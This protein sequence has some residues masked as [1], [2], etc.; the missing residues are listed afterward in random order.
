MFS[1]VVGK[2]LMIICYYWVPW[3]IDAKHF[4]IIKKYGCIFSLVKCFTN[5]RRCR[6]QFN[7]FKFF[8]FINKD[9][10]DDPKVD[11]ITLFNLMIFIEM[12]M[13]L[14]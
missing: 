7:N 3:L 4:K 1:L 11:Y 13:E 14:K 2:T 9:W 12:D 6:L 8:I 5:L 10:L